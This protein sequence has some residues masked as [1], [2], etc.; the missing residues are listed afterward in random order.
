MG[1]FKESVKRLFSNYKPTSVMY[2]SLD[3][4]STNNIIVR[5]K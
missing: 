3:N 4:I 5:K 1:V 2:F